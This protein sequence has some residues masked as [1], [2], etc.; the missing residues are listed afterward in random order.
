M[1]ENESRAIKNETRDGDSRD[2]VEY[3]ETNCTWRSSKV[4]D[5]S[6]IALSKAHV[7][8]ISFGRAL[9]QKRDV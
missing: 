4:P 6:E 7:V 5:V 8:V 2:R 1:I 9:G 3:F